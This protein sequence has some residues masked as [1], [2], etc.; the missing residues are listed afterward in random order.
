MVHT[1][2]SFRHDGEYSRSYYVMEGEGDGYLA[3]G[4]EIVKI[5]WSRESLESPFVY[6]LEDGTPVTLGVGRTYVAVACG[7]KGTVDYQ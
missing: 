7:A 2:Q 5:K 3:M 4:G 1:D 6:T